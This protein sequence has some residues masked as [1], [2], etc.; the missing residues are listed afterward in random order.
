MR[1]PR[2]KFDNPEGF[3]YCGECGLSLT[4]EESLSDFSNKRESER[5]QITVIFCDL[6]NSTSL[7]E[8]L[9]TEIF[10]NL[11]S[12]YQ[13]V[14]GKIIRRFEGHIAQYLGDGILVYFGYPTA[15]EDDALRAVLAGLEIANEI[16]KLN[17]KLAG[18]IEILEKIPL[19]ARIGIHTGPVMVGEIG[20]G[21]KSD[22][23]ALGDT[24]N[25]ASRI[26]QTADPGEV[27]VSSATH[28]I[29]EGY[30]SS[31]SLGYHEIKGITKPLV[32]YRIIEA[33]ELSNRF[34]IKTL[35]GLTPFV[36]RDQ[37]L[38][39]LHDAW[40]NVIH[41]SRQIVFLEGEAGIGKSRL[42]E[43]LV[44]SV[45]SSKP[46]IVHLQC[47]PYYKNSSLYPI[48]KLFERVFDIKTIDSD[49]IKIDK[50]CSFLENENFNLQE[51][52]PFILALFSIPSIMQYPLPFMG[53]NKQREIT[54]TIIKN[55]LC[56]NKG[57]LPILFIIEDLQWADSSTIELFKQIA[58]S[59]KYEI[60]LTIYT[61]RPKFLPPMVNDAKITLNPLEGDQIDTMITNLANNKILPEVIVKKIKDI[62]S[63]IPLFIEELT[64]MI[65]LSTYLK[66]DLTE[67][68]LVKTIDEIDIPLTLKDSLNARLDTA[69]KAKEVA[70]I[71]AIIGREFSYNLIE[72]VS[73]LEKDTLQKGLNI[74]VESD[75]LHYTI[76]DENIYYIFNHALIHEAAYDSTVKS[77]RF[78]YHNKVADTLE[79][80][81]KYVQSTRPEILAYH[82]TEAKQIRRA[83][84]YY[85]KAGSEALEKSAYDESIEFLKLGIN[86]SRTLPE[87]SE[88]DQIEI[89][90]LL[91]KSEPL[92][93]KHGWADKVLESVYERTMFLS[94]KTSDARSNLAVLKGFCTMH[95]MRGE[96]ELS[97]KYAYSLLKYAE[98]I[99]D[100]K[101]LF[102]A[103][104]LVGL[105]EF[106]K[107]NFNKTLESH[108][109]GLVLYSDAT[110]NSSIHEIN[111]VTT[112]LFLN[113]VTS[114]NHLV[115]GNIDTAFK[116]FNQQIDIATKSNNYF[117]L[118]LV[119]LS[120]ATGYSLIGDLNECKKCLNVV[121][122]ISEELG[123][124]FLFGQALILQG[125]IDRDYNS[126]EGLKLIQQGIEAY[127]SND[128]FLDFPRYK[129]YLADAYALRGKY[130]EA[131]EIIERAL[132][133][134]YQNDD[135]SIESLLYL[136]K[137]NIL[138][139]SS[140]SDL[141]TVS[142]ILHKAHKI[143]LRQSCKLFE[144]K[145]S[146][147][148]FELY[149]KLGK[150][151][152]GT[153]LL[154][155]TYNKFE[156]GFHIN[157]MKAAH[158]ILANSE[159]KQD[160]NKLMDH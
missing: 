66:E 46:N 70:Q 27:I 155:D 13:E 7:S 130:E 109:K 69:L 32:L 56:L 43:E 44:E 83:L 62:S 15:H 149:N 82:L 123:L 154:L 51:T 22:H 47:S 4:D 5:R 108:K 127:A 21:E 77:N 98:S 101:W 117:H 35:K 143:T 122:K 55:I 75:I 119:N 104:T 42:I 54:F 103:Y 88:R 12:T 153:T 159:Y 73:T 121:Y 146:L 52:L 60:N 145:T 68:R 131:L 144:I 41:G 33:S 129:M 61:Y 102:E 113:M 38:K 9:D 87:S 6:V 50:I 1:C 99:N 160:I 29:I 139:K 24:P 110:K 57:T 89:D 115:L 92:L 86:L 78:K 150:R 95:S 107:G 157:D 94:E 28:E 39:K 17:T 90:L 59:D 106:Y 152:Y 134:A 2:C 37:E 58:E 48:I 136:L 16:K 14:S 79:N 72:S 133:I 112:S 31:D 76:S 36:G 138:L 147:S 120:C 67:Y 74:L 63:G 156:E 81:D 132:E 19:Q 49:K 11:I 64:K 124:D 3:K 45:L 141:D 158:E 85:L 10:H 80:D 23:L 116:Y 53:S 91:A 135:L 40:E 34:K 71:G 8:N 30:F 97:I 65:I 96:S 20:N 148:L 125:W 114:A 105:T 18:N 140:S 111:P 100:W 151:K 84:P 25:I 26:L 142:E 118:A 137:G 93:N 126:D 128:A